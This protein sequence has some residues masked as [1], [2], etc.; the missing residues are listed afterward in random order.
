MNTVIKND[1]NIDTTKV[2]QIIDYLC[3]PSFMKPVNRKGRYWTHSFGYELDGEDVLINWYDLDH[4]LKRRAVIFTPTSLSHAIIKRNTITVIAS[5][6]SDI[7]KK[8]KKPCAVRITLYE[9]K[10]I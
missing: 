6:R 9:H 7:C 5:G 2:N 8:D 4:R 1:P 10:R 3:R